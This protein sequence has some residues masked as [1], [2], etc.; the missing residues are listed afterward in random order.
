MHLYLT[1]SLSFQSFRIY[2]TITDL[3]P[4]FLFQMKLL[5]IAPRDL[6]VN[7]LMQTQTMLYHVKPAFLE[8]AMPPPTVND[9]SYET[10][11]KEQFRSP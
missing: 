5:R 10:T 6:I 8:D 1:S 3:F 9:V 11:L 7:V 4:L 2:R